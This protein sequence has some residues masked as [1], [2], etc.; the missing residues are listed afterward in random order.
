VRAP[1]LLSD[2][3]PCKR[4]TRKALEA[5]SGWVRPLPLCTQGDGVEAVEAHPAQGPRLVVTPRGRR[6]L[7]GTPGTSEKGVTHWERAAASRPRRARRHALETRHALSCLRHLSRLNSLLGTHMRG[8]RL[9]PRCLR[10][11]GE[12][13]RTAFQLTPL[14]FFV[15]PLLRRPPC[16]TPRCPQ[17]LAIVSPDTG[18]HTSGEGTGD[19]PLFTEVRHPTLNLSRAAS[20]RRAHLARLTR[21]NSR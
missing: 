12:R 8:R 20:R 18:K 16:A 11:W 2:E 10:R 3:A 1:R 15:S 4:R 9:E 14:V 13:L 5:H 6:E 19:Q 17:R 7:L 21:P